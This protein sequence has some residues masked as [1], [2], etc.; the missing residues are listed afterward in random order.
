MVKVQIFC[1]N[2]FTGFRSFKGISNLNLSNILFLLLL[3]LLIII[4]IIIVIVKLL[5]LLL[6]LLLQ[7]EQTLLNY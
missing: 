7:D 5:L 2:M 3:L 4:I 1:K 6:L